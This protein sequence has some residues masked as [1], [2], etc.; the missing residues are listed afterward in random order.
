MYVYYVAMEYRKPLYQEYI[1]YYYD[2]IPEGLGGSLAYRSSSIIAFWGDIGLV[3]LIIIL[4][5]YFFQ[6]RKSAASFK[7]NNPVLFNL[8]IGLGVLMIVQSFILNVFEGNSF[9]MNLFW[10]IC[11]ISAASIPVMKSKNVLPV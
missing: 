6:I 5:I 7:G 3:G 11:G 4:V 9:T 1:M 2:L 10:I 8:V